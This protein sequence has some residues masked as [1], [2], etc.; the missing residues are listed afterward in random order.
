MEWYECKCVCEQV[1]DLNQ[2]ELE[3]LSNHLGHELQIHKSFYRLHESTIE[4]SKVSRLLMAVDAGQAAKYCGQKLDDINID[5]GY[6][7]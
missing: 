2:G 3:W 1:I 5:G 4:L 7:C 6:H